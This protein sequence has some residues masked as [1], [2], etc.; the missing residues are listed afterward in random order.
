M[1]RPTYLHSF[2]TALPPFAHPQPALNDWIVSAHLRAESLR[3]GE[4]PREALGAVMRRF[5]VSEDKIARRLVECSDVDAAWGEHRVYR[6]T[7]ATPVGAD[8]EGRG[9]V[10]AES[11]QR[12]F[13]EFY[14]GQ[15]AP[16]H[17]IHVSC[18]GYVSPSPAQVYFSTARE[19]PAITHAYHMGCYAAFPAVRIAQAFCQLSSSARGVDIVH[20]EV[21][22]L[23]LR[24]EDHSPEQMVVQSLFADGHIKYSATTTPVGRALRVLHVKEQL[25]RDSL[26]DMT[27]VP[28]PHGMKMTLSRE[29]PDKIRRGIA[30]FVRDLCAE[31]ALDPQEVLA[32]AIFAVH[33]GGP[34]IIDSVQEVLGLSEAQVATSKRVLRERGNMSSATLPHVWQELLDARDFS[35]GRIVVGLAFGPGLTMFGGVFELVG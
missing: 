5:C 33:P 34:K 30:D 12:T 28:G 3:T 14:A 27:W 22:S 2:R 19:A 23:H 6:L 8:I 31:S 32:S 9:R 10:Y 13:R 18:T 29:V 1:S 7:D 35:P 26:G 25:V 15:E 17:L 11:V 24:A 4:A 16:A 20:N 21:C